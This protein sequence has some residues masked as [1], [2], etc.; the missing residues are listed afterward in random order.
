MNYLKAL[1]IQVGS[2]IPQ[3]FE[4]VFL[5]CFLFALAFLSRL[6][7]SEKVPPFDQALVVYCQFSLLPKQ[8]LCTLL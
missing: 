4:E 5:F 6:F 8:P 7:L 2:L 1:G 3:L